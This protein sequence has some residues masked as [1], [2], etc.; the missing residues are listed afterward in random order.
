MWLLWKYIYS[1]F[2][3]SCHSI[4]REEVKKMK[5]FRRSLNFTLFAIFYKNPRLIAMLKCTMNKEKSSVCSHV[6]PFSNQEQS[7]AQKLAQTMHVVYVKTSTWHSIS[8]SVVLP[9]KIQLMNGNFQ[10]DTAFS[11]TLHYSCLFLT[12]ENT[13][14]TQRILLKWEITWDLSADRALKI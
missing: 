10:M 3:V 5:G 7:L 8:I 13:E 11:R 2:C 14:N 1:I 6:L 4:W 9:R 12:E